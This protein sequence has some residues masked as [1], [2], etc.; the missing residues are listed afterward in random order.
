M[1]N[2]YQIRTRDHPYITSAKGLSGWTKKVIVADFHYIVGAGG[3]KKVQTFADIIY[4]LSPC[5]KVLKRVLL[6]NH[7]K[8]AIAKKNRI[9]KLFVVAKGHCGLE[10]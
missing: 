1:Y 3:S 6:K 9:N 4:G 5:E 10:C 2:F 7:R 8:L